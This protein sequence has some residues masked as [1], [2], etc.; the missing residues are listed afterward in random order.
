MSRPTTKADRYTRHLFILSLLSLASSRESTRTND[1]KQVFLRMMPARGTRED[2]RLE[3]RCNEDLRLE[4]GCY[5]GTDRSRRTEKP[6]NI[7]LHQFSFS[8]IGGIFFVVQQKVGH[9]LFPGPATT[10][11]VR[12]TPTQLFCQFQS[13]QA[14]GFGQA[15]EGIPTPPATER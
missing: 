12:R 6:L 1:V 13:R 14:L 2:L 10:L 3:L 4:L 15:M 5:T 11:Q 8:T 7:R 9:T